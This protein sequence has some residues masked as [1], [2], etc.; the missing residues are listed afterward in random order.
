MIKISGVVITHNEEHNITRCIRSL[1]A[2]ADEI[3]IVD[4]FSNDSTVEIAESMG[5]RVIKHPFTGYGE[6]KNFAQEQAN[7]DWI[8]NIDADEEITPELAQSILG[9][10]EK[11]NHPAYK[12]NILTNYSGT[13]IRHSGWY[14]SYK[15]RLWDRKQG[16][17]VENAVHERWALNTSHVNVP[18]LN[19]DLLHY[20]YSSISDHISRI[21]TYTE[22]GARFAAENGKSYSLFQIWFSPK[23]IFFN[24]Y[25]LR[26]GFR[27]GY[28]GFVICKLSAITAFIKYSKTREFAKQLRLKAAI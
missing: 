1:Q 28:Y 8:L 25:F 3:L 5:A 9:V 10:K 11:A 14:P 6:Q 24:Q 12:L 2:V 13:W 27:D 4:S 7:Y 19:G 15:L 18:K 21:E 22:L 17:M 16:H 23:W 20:S 26:G